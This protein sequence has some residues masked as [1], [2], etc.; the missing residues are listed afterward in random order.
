MYGPEALSSLHKAITRHNAKFNKF[1]PVCFILDRL[2]MSLCDVTGPY[3]VLQNS[4]RDV[5]KSHGTPNVNIDVKTDWLVAQQP[6]NQNQRYKTVIK[7]L[8]V[9]VS[10][11]TREFGDPFSMIKLICHSFH[12]SLFY[13]NAAPSICTWNTYVLISSDWMSI[14]D[15]KRRHPLKMY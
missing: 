7:S 5:T 11:F 15:R 3:F 6:V 12:L 14:Q 10:P 8:C 4:R 13:T 9:L 2:S 1:I